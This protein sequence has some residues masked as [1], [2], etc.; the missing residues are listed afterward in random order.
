MNVDELGTLSA[1]DGTTEPASGR[2]YGGK[3]A[4]ERRADR[5][6]RLIDAA[7]ELFGTEGYATTT[8][9][10]LCRTASVTT[11][12]F[13]D[14]FGTREALLTELYD[15]IVTAAADAV[16][17][18]LTTSAVDRATRTRTGLAAYLHAMLDDPRR[19]RIQCIESVGVSPEFEVHRRQ[20]VRNYQ[21]LLIREAGTMAAA[22]GRTVRLAHF[23]AD[24]L[25]G[26]ANAAMIAWLGSPRPID[27]L[28][29]ELSSIYIAVG[30]TFSDP[31]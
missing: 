29:A 15:E 16:A 30:E 7:L 19:A 12:H 11:Q 1:A 13:Y 28:V 10:G 20:I 3:S 26:A 17:E 27:D 31:A 5:R 21:A 18:A 2:R 25:V 4:E 24:A 9:T 23:V 6:R 14:E 8:I 22:E